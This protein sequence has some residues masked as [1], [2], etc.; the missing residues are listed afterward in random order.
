LL[1]LFLDDYRDAQDAGTKFHYTWL[2]ILIALEAW[3]KKNT[4]HFATKKESVMQ[5]DMKSYDI[6]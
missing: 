2:L 5:Q 3:E 4:Q 6:I 1:N